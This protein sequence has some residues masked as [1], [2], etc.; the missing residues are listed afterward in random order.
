M[1]E[2]KLNVERRADTGKGAARRARVAGKVPGIVYGQGMDP[3]PVVVDRR[4]FVAALSSDTG[5]NTLLQ[6]KLDGKAVTTLAREVQRD[7]IR[8][9]LLHADFVKVDLKQEVEVE[10]PV[11]LVGD[12]PGVG[13]G[14]VLEQPLHTLAV[15]CLP[16]KVPEAIE[17]DVSNLGIGES[18]HVS[19]LPSGADYEIVTSGEE[20]VA[21]IVAPISEAD[22]AAME[23]D[24]GVEPTAVETDQGPPP[25]TATEGA[26]GDADAQAGE[27]GAGGTET[28]SEQ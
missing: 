15:R 6:F 12:A 26:A 17:A 13:E 18:L 2:V 7:P 20:A 14:G 25:D 5:F 10:V 1:A 16:A 27:G 9:T 3:V 11:H 8:G 23:A 22:L 19:D 21:T 4:E 28:P 24:A